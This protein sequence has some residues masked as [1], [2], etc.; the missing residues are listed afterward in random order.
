V[1]PVVQAAD[2]WQADHFADLGRYDRAGG[3]RVLVEGE[4][5]AGAMVVV[6]V[7]RLKSAEMALT[8]DDD[9][10]IGGDDLRRG[11]LSRCLTYQAGATFQ[12]VCDE[13][14]VEGF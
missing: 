1:V 2:L 13:E 4:I 6:E 9:V 10:D 3:G 5:R 12:K 14:G 11:A 8:E 7:G